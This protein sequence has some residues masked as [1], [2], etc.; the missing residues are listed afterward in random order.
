MGES[1]TAIRSGQSVSQF[2]E[3]SMSELGA[4]EQRGSARE[5]RAA[6]ARLCRA[7]GAPRPLGPPARRRAVWPA[8]A[9]FLAG[10]GVLSHACGTGQTPSPRAK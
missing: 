10:V 1:E 8:R 9:V 4:A 3:G 6:S 7:H 5:A 2:D